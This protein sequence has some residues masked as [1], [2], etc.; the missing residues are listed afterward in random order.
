MISALR[1][2]LNSSHGQIL[3]G[4]MLAGA[5]LSMLQGATQALRDEADQLQSD[6]QGARAELARIRRLVDLARLEVQAAVDQAEADKPG[7]DIDQ[8][9]GPGLLDELDR[10]GAIILGADH[11]ALSGD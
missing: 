5:G 2:F 7:E 10:A 9:E 11:P 1:R 6:N 4:A 8:P 3:V